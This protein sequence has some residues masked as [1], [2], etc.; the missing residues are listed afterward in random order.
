LERLRELTTGVFGAPM[1]R[2]RAIL[3]TKVVLTPSALLM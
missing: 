1:T 3:I 2:T